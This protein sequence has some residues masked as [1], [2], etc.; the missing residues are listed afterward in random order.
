MGV[1]VIFIRERTTDP[2]ELAVYLREAPGTLAGSPVTVHAF[3]GAHQALEGPEVESVIIIE[4]PSHE[5]VRA[6]YD[7]EAYQQ[8]RQ[9]RLRGGEYRVLLVEGQQR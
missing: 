3:G 7:S 4:F 5:A 9:H 8:V 2:S 1:Y 6:W